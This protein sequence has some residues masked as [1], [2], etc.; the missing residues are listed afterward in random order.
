MTVFNCQCDDVFPS[1][2]LLNLR[3]RLI[4][5]L[6]FSAQATN[7]PPGMADLMDSFLQEA[8]EMLYMEYDAFQ[9][10]RFFTWSCVEGERFYDLFLNDESIELTAPSEG[11]SFP[12][13]TGG[14]LVAGTYTHRISAVNANG[15]TLADC[16]IETIIASG[17][18]GRCALDWAAGAVAGATAYKIYGRT[19]GSELYIDT[20]IGEEFTYIDDG[21]ITPAGALPTSNTTAECTKLISPHKVRWVGISDENGEWYKLYEGIDPAWYS[22]DIQ[23]NWPG[24]YEIRQ[25][26]ELWPA[27]QGTQQLRIKG[28][29]GLLRFTQDTDVTTIDSTAVFLRALANAKAHYGK[30]DAGNYASQCENHVMNLVAATHK[31]TYCTPVAT[32]C[33]NDALNAVDYGSN[34]R[35]DSG[36][37]IRRDSN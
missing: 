29:F 8:Q 2:T 15:E 9:I 6:G 14:S 24:R 22:G 1:E 7:P 32:G 10:E 28:D 13:L 11:S 17:V 33:E 20:V 34:V 19:A 3:R 27:P 16:V 21:S 5:R 4:R 23:T 31:G 25:C 12:F 26:I 35:Y 18:A 37:N 30:G 36:G